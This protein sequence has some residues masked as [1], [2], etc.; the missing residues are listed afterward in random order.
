MTL[1]IDASTAGI[2]G[3]MLLCSLVHMGADSAKI[4][5]ALRRAAD[6]IPDVQL[7]DFGFEHVKRR[8]L[9][10]IALRLE[11]SR[12][13]YWNNASEITRHLVESAKS[14]NLSSKA[15]TFIES[16]INTLI[17][18]ESKVHGVSNSSVHLHEAASFDTI[19][20][21]LGTGIA[22]DDLD[23]FSESI[24]CTPVAVGG[25]TIEFSHG[26]ASNPAPAILEIL[27]NQNIE[28]CGGPVNSELCTPTGASMLVNLAMSCKRIYPPMSPTMMG[29]GAGSK[30]YKEFS[31]V[32]KLVRGNTISSLSFDTVRVLETNLDD[33]TGELLG[34][35]IDMLMQRGAYDVTVSAAVTKK[36]R[37]TSLVTVMCDANHYDEVLSC[38]ID[39]TGTLG[40]RVRDSE[41][42]VVQ[43]DSK[44]ADITIND[45]NF[46]IRYK[47][48]N[49]NV[50]KVEHDDVAR[51][52]SDLKITLQQAR[53]LLDNAI[54]GDLK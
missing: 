29:Y 39:E 53:K 27:K 12:D 44:I 15:K 22:L 35:V 25:G 28:I 9:A 16:S 7:G 41:R 20:D 2:S 51:V 48:T 42:I 3:D 33:V 30:E 14:E 10:S 45:H 40:V 4:E 54:H 32:L 1:V 24:F 13:A 5:S 46:K 11:I 17:T 36:G 50:L 8:G 18:A 19:I 52:S 34:H 23:I 47:T 31:N 49:T 21:I 26:I 38:L 43:R 37:P 6:R